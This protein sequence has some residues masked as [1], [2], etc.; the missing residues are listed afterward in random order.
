MARRYR[1]HRVRGYYRNGKYVRGH[2]KSYPKAGV[3]AVGVVVFLLV[4]L[5]LAKMGENF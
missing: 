5:V 1:R 2:L 4:V 3:G